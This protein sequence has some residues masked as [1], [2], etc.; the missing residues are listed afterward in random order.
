MTGRNH[1]EGVWR[2]GQALFLDRSSLVIGQPHKLASTDSPPPAEQCAG[3]K[4]V[5]YLQHAHQDVSPVA[6]F[7]LALGADAVHQVQ[8]ELAGHGLD[9]T[10]QGLVVNVLGKE[11][12]GEGEVT[13]GQVLTDVVHKV[14]QRAV[15]EGPVGRNLH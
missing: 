15:G 3:L 1:E 9:A 8:Q 10:G 12:D 7:L 14:G 2:T 6:A 13:E 5:R 11:L 4:S